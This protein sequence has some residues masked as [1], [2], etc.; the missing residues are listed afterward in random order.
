MTLYAVMEYL[1]VF[2]VTKVLICAAV[3]SPLF[4][5]ISNARTSAYHPQGNSQVERFNHTVEAMQY[6]IVDKL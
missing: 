2:T 1:L 4:A 3:S 5:V 6:K